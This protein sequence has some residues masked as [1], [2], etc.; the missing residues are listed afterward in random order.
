MRDKDGNI[1]GLL[2]ITVNQEVNRIP[3]A[4]IDMIHRYLVKNAKGTQNFTL[5]P[6]EKLSTPTDAPAPHDFSPGTQITVLLGR[7]KERKEVFSGYV[8]KHNIEVTARNEQMVSIECRHVANRM[9][10]HPRTR[11]FHHQANNKASSKDSIDPVNE[12]SVLEYLL[13]EVHK[14]LKLKPNIEKDLSTSE[15]ENMTQYRC[16]DWDFMVMRAEANGMVCLPESNAMRFFEP[17]VEATADRRLVMGKDILEY[18]AWFDESIGSPS[19]TYASW[20]ANHDKVV[21]ELDDKS[22][23]ADNP[24]AAKIQSD[25]F[26]E[27]GAAL[28]PSETKAILEGEVLRQKL[29]KLRGMIRIKG[30][31]DI[32]VGATIAVEGFK[33]VWDG[34]TFVS[35]I[36][37]EVRAGLWTMEVQ[38]GLSEKTHAERYNLEATESM[39]PQTNGLLYGVV[40]RYKKDQYGRELV[41]VEIAASNESNTNT[42]N[43]EWQGKSVYARLSSLLAS[44]ERGATF[45]PYPG[46]EVVLGFVAND[47][48][49]P[50][51]LGSVYNG[52][53][54]PLFDLKDEKTQEE[55]GFTIDKWTWK[56]NHEDGIMEMKSPD[57]QLISIEEKDN[58]GKISIQYNDSNSMELS[59]DGLT[60]NVQAITMEAKEDVTING[61]NIAA[62]GKQNVDIEGNAKVTV[63]GKVNTAI[64]GQTLNVN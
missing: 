51:V 62:A 19:N 42:K 45:R 37:H 60:I 54:K 22:N 9:T 23:K 6:S 58:E 15:H 3:R 38:C 59:K 61:Q 36:R 49:F 34:N 43:E 21:T 7:G 48:R 27:H 46:D 24:D 18:E 14:D 35:G 52:K 33:S 30:A 50:V 39:M 5:I 11:F 55:I 25:L 8:V 12:K 41:E 29:G 32:Q 10:L 64:K 4:R 26:F 20:K 1:P 40:S 17:K 44:E 57:G 56:I 16:S 28:E 13:Q 53:R 31:T 47:P 63:E 2:G